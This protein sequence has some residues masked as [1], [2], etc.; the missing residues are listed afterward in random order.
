[1]ARKMVEIGQGMGV[2]VTALLTEMDTPLGYAVGNSL[3]VHSFQPLPKARPV[4]LL[5]EER[6]RGGEEERRRGGEEERRRGGEEE[7]RRGG[8]EERR[9]GGEERIVRMYPISIQIIKPSYC[10]LSQFR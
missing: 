6:R 8:E 2:D 10:I 5:L 3:E 1:M 9:R 4:A 7:R